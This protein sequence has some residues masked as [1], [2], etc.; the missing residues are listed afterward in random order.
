MAEFNFGPAK[1]QIGNMTGAGASASGASGLVPAPSAGDNSKFLKGDGTWSAIPD[2]NGKADKVVSATNGNFA[3]LDSN[4]NLTDSGKSAAD[5]VAATAVGASSGVAELD[6]NGKVPT[7]QL[8]SYVDDVI[9]G[10]YYNSKFYKESTHTTEI[11][12]E[13]G[14]IYVD[15]S[16]EKTYRW[17]GSA[18]V[19]ISSSLALGET[20]STAYRGDRGKTAYDHASDASRSTTAQ[21]SGLYKIATTAEGHVASVAAVQKSDITG[22]GIPGQDTTYSVMTGAGAS[23]SGES[24]LVPAPASGDNEKV[25][26]GDGTWKIVDALP[27]VTSSDNGKV[28]KVVS[29]SWVAS[30]ESQS[31]A[32]KISLSIA[33]TDWTS[34]TGGYTA[35]VTDSHITASSEEIVIYDDSI[36]N[37]TSGISYTKTASSNLL[38]FFVT[39][40][41][42]GT[43]S[44]RILVI[45]GAIG[46][47]TKLNANQGSSNSGK[48]MKV[49]SDG[50]LTPANIPAELPSVSSSD[51]GKVLRVVEGVWTA[52]SI[53]NASGVSF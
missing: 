10:Y 50:V 36:E 38:T 30:T 51:N 26:Y 28:L 21:A 27:S 1:K 44:G 40:V 15:L 4:G 29:G 23:A 12:G 42:S 37:L 24:G 45:G 11:T 33:T 6:E 7:S 2:P 53:S 48:Y 43:I 9:E 22:L 16:T 52:A 19:E 32:Y 31:G 34:A 20:S 47:D 41:P 5:F 17:G 8:P 13:T 46:V 14:K 25:L 3:G 35:T 18:Y 39:S 49:G